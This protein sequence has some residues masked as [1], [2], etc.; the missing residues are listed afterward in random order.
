MIFK[1]KLKQNKIKNSA[2]ASGVLKSTLTN[3]FNLFLHF[4]HL[5][6]LNTTKNGLDVGECGATDLSS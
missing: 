5:P 3:N 2:K 4:C 1:K 6:P